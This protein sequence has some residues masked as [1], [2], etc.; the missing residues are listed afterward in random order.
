[1]SDKKAIL[2]CRSPEAGKVKTRLAKEIGHHQAF[3]VYK[4]LLEK[5]IKEVKDLEIPLAAYLEGNE[6][7]FSESLDIDFEI[8]AQSSGDLGDRMQNAFQVEFH[9]GYGSIVLFGADIIGLSK[10]DIEDSFSKLDS[11]DLVIGPARD[12][13][14]Y[15]IGM[16]YPNAGIFEGIQWG[17][18]DVLNETLTKAKTLGLKVAFLEEKR[19]VDRLEDVLAIPELAG[20]LSSVKD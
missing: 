13:G 12:G 20:F 2:F 3:L 11:A 6:K 4:F 16:K 8:R 5:I 14:Y 19:D 9:E 7:V 1:M 18:P 17:G 10:R 15:L